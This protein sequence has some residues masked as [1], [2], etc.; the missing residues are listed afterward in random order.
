[1]R[2]N[3]R[4]PLGTLIPNLSIHYS[5]SVREDPAVNCTCLTDTST[6]KQQKPKN[7]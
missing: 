5:L 3:I 6:L 1:M 2:V 7:C 4:T